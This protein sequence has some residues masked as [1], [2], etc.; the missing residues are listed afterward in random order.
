MT[1]TPLEVFNLLTPAEKQQVL[2]S[3]KRESPSPC[4][5]R[6]HKYKPV[7]TTNYLFQ[8]LNK[9]TMCCTQCGKTIRV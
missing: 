5:V 2:A 1:L 4:D 6:G 8:F 9:T 7:A 3:I